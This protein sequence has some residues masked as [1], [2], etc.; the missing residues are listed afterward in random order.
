LVNYTLSNFFLAGQWGGEDK[1]S[2]G[3]GRPPHCLG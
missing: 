1:R 2:G 3:Q